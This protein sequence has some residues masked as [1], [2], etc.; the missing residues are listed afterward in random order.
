MS[1][2]VIFINE[3]NSFL[4]LVFTG[5]VAF[6]TVIYALLT[7][8]MVKET[9]AMRQVYTDPKVDFVIRPQRPK[10]GIFDAWVKNI[11]RGPAYNVKFEIEP[12]SKGEVSERTLS[13]LTSNHFISEG[14]NYLSP[15]QSM[16]TYLDNMY[17][18]GHEKFEVKFNVTVTYYS[19]GGVEFK[20]TYRIEFSEQIGGSYIINDY[21]YESSKH[22]DKI[23]QNIEK[24]ANGKASLEVNIYDK[25]DRELCKK[26][27]EIKRKQRNNQK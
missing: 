17:D 5:V 6:S 11:G 24:I 25:N 7:M 20:D 16:D 18:Q 4:T 14:I 21:I 8:S 23:S 27:L 22:L 15:N 2:F 9:R 1:E 10:K 13:E 12:I 3:N 26:E 19:S